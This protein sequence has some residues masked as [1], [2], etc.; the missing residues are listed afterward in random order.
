MPYTIRRAEPSDAAA[1][2]QIA[3]GRSAYSNTMQLPWPSLAMWQR[4]CEQW[5]DHLHMLVAETPEGQVVGNVGL[6]A[7]QS[8]RRRHVGQLGM[9]VHD[10]WQGK[11]VGSALLAAAIE[12]AEQWLALTRLEL[13]VYTDNEAGLALYRKYG[14]ESEGV[15]RAAAFRDGALVDVERM[16]RLR[17]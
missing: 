7:L 4:R 9:F 8:P 15:A 12:L 1:F 13:E 17:P 6:E 10:Q 3:A 2:Q 5:P 14:F 11:G 16:A